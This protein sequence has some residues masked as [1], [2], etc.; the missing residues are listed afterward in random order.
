MVTLTNS[1]LAYLKSVCPP[2]NHI[3]LGVK[4]GGCS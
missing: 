1:A 3:T 4:G 2:E